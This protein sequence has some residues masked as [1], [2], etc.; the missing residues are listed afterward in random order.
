MGWLFKLVDEKGLKNA[1]KN[2][3]SF[4][5]PIFEFVGSEGEIVRFAKRIYRKY[6]KKGLRVEPSKKDLKDIKKWCEIYIKTHN[7]KVLDEEDIITETKVIFCAMMQSFCG[8][9]TNEDLSMETKM[10]KYISK[11]KSKDK[12]AI[13]KVDEKVFDHRQWRSNNVEGNYTRFY[14]KPDDYNDFSGF[15]RVLEIKY[16]K[17]FDDQGKLLTI[18]NKKKKRSLSNFFNILSKKFKWQ[19]KKRIL[20]VLSSF[21]PNCL[22]IGCNKVYRLEKESI[23]LEEKVYENLVDAIHY[24]VNGPRYVYLQLN[25]GELEIIELLQER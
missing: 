16:R 8:Y 18:F 15:M 22:R 24:C 21:Q 20:F 11:F 9:F 12:I 13:I 3:I 6:E 2:I 7:N 17:S 1:K 5:R 25:A 10:I 23:S 4:S 14:G 19:K